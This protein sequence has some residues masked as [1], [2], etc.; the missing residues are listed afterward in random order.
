M[1]NEVSA[2]LANPKRNYAKGVELYDK[3]KINKKFDKFFA[4][5]NNPE[6]GSPQ[7]QLLY[8]KLATIDRKLKQNTQLVESEKPTVKKSISVKAINT[9]KKGKKTAKKSDDKT[10]KNDPKRPRI[11]E[12]PL[13]DVKELPDDLKVKYFE[14]KERTK[15]LSQKHEE[16][17]KAK[18]DKDRKLI[19]DQIT[20]LENDRSAAWKEIDTWWNA[21]KKQDMSPTQDPEIVKQ[22]NKIS[23][24]KNYIRRANADSKKHPDKKEANDKKVEKW[25]KELDELT[26]G[27]S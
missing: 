6:P 26:K 20:V 16:L 2:W 25:Q 3:Y 1:A 15:L 9:D 27:N 14:N 4:S 17:K 23:N 21:N 13:I 7:S 11:V 22:A 8:K 24:L 10:A 5:A 18:T 12:N 19:A